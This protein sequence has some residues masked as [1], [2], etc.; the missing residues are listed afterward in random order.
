MNN[1]LKIIKYKRWIIIITNNDEIYNI[2]NK[3]GLLI[4]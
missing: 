3:L 4:I 1:P 2:N